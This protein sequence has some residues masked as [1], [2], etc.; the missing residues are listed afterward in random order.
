MCRRSSRHLE[1]ADL[2]VVA[3]WRQGRR[4][5]KVLASRVYNVVMRKMGGVDVHDGNWIKAMRRD[6]VESF[7]PLRSDWH[8]FLLMIAAHNGFRVGE[9]QTFYQPRPAGSSKFG[10][11]RIPKSLL[12]VLGAQILCWPLATHPCA[13]LAGLAWWES[14][15]AC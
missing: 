12:D 1:A 7:P 8:R 6:V 13:F 4:D 5:N 9:V 2:D 3:G 14:S 15:P 10:W 11:E